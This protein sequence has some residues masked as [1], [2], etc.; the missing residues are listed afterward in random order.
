MPVLPRPAV[1][2]DLLLVGV[3]AEHAHVGRS[4]EHSTRT[5][6]SRV[7]SQTVSAGLT[8]FFRSSTP[9]VQT[10]PHSWRGPKRSSSSTGPLRPC[11][12][13]P[14]YIHVDLAFI[15]SALA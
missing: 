12:M 15:T 4:I 2:R 13:S 3:D 14:K 8:T 11:W 5:R 7:V 1:G 10:C 9:G 6:P